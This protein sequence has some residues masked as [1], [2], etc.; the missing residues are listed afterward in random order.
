MNAFRRR[1][2]ACNDP[3]WGG[4]LAFGME[5]AYQ[6]RRF[7]NSAGLPSVTARDHIDE[8]GMG[9]NTVPRLPVTGG[10]SW[11]RNSSSGRA[12][13]LT[14]WTREMSL[15]RADLDGH[16]RMIIDCLNRLCP[17]IEAT[18][19]EQEIL[20]VIDT[21]EEF[22]LVH[23]GE[24]ERI[25]KAAGYPGWASHKTQHDRMYELVFKMQ[26]NV[27]HGHLPD[28]RKLYETLYEWLTQHIMGED[29]KFKPYLDNYHPS[30]DDIRST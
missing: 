7:G 28:A 1:S 19:Q 23:F 9:G 24:E 4:K 16:H 2:P 3:L 13:K 14:A 6:G 8:H 27:V 15:G 18:G 29:R 5:K 17:L 25:M 11:S 10:S 21:L 26:A 12:M 20:G 22:V 30:Q